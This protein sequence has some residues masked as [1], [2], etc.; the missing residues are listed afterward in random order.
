MH[1]KVVRK[2]VQVI[3]EQFHSHL[4]GQ[5]CECEDTAI[6]PTGSNTGPDLPEM[7]IPLLQE[8]LQMHLHFHISLMMQLEQ[9]PDLFF[10]CSHRWR[11]KEKYFADRMIAMGI[12][13][14]QWDPSAYLGFS[15]ATQT[16][17]I[18]LKFKFT[19][20]R[21]FFQQKLR[22]KTEFY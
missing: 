18:E 16:T 20:P 13:V 8:M 7:C 19:L 2:A 5:Q 15:V 3:M 21:L 11:N 12:W 9:S 6:I 4:P 22:Y 14:C 1:P 10:I 17:K